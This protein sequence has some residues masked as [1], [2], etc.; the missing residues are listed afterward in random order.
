MKNGRITLTLILLITG[1][2]NLL[3]LNFDEI[4]LVDF[5]STFSVGLLSEVLIIQ[6]IV[7]KKKDSNE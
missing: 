5:L 2:S 3:R 4:K 7:N 6:I 1:I